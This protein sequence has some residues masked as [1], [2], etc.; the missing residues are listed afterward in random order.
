[1]SASVANACPR[2]PAVAAQYTFSRCQQ[3]CCLNCCYSMPDGSICCAPCYSQPQAAAVA[4][5]SVSSVQ[6]QSTSTPARGCPQHPVLPPVAFCKVCGRGSCVT[7]DFSFPPNI[8]L[9]PECVV[10]S[11]S[12]LTPM[13]KKYMVSALVMAVW[14]SIGM[15]L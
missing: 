1:M 6:A 5:P 13:R 9:C 7:C 4:T 8:H 3:P 2:H 15:G 14:S 12:A 10:S 11:Q